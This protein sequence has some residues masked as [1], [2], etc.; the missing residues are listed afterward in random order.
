[1]TNIQDDV[2]A[3]RQMGAATIRVRPMSKAPIS[4]W[5]GRADEAEK[6]QP[7]EQPA[8]GWARRRGADRLCRGR[9]PSASVPAVDSDVRSGKQAPVAL[10]PPVP[11]PAHPQIVLYPRP[12]RVSIA[13]IG[14]RARS[15][16]GR[17]RLP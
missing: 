3:L 8:F 13:G 6:F 12:L 17:E 15:Q 16:L 5:Q 9:R 11:R 2:R 14:Q 4:K 10:D 7:G 1:M